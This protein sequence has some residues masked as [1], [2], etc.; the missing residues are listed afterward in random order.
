M[1]AAEM[2]GAAGATV[3]CVLPGPGGR[4]SLPAPH[5]RLTSAGPIRILHNDGLLAGEA[6]VKHNNNLSR[7][8]ELGHARVQ[9][10]DLELRAG[11]R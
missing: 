3:G 8:Q 11:V 10:G 7:T 4:R 2:D 9:V 6:S 1:H 5:A